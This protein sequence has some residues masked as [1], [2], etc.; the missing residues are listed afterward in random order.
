M[1]FREAVERACEEPTL[2]DALVWIAVWETSRVVEQAR[3]FSR[4][5]IS[6]AAQGEYD[7]TF[8]ILFAGVERRWDERKQENAKIKIE[9]TCVGGEMDKRFYLPGVLVK[10]VCPKCGKPNTRDMGDDYL[11]YPIAGKPFQI[12]AYCKSCEHEWKVT[13]ILRITLEPGE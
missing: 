11:S 6:T 9:G 3:E 13:V 10:T 7:T 8:K 2:K 12:G 4:T 1:R 5:G